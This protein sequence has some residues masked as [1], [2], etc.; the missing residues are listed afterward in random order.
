M[1]GEV[2]LDARQQ[3][4]CD[5]SIDMPIHR[6]S[7]PPVDKSTIYLTRLEITTSC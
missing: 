5:R 7:L 3:S 1:R 6:R 2:R 4:R